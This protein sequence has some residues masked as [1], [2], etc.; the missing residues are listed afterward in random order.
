MVVKFVFSGQSFWVRIFFLPA[1]LHVTPCCYDCLL[2]QLVVLRTW[3]VHREHDHGAL[4]TCH[5]LLPVKAL[6]TIR[7]VNHAHHCYWMHISPQQ[8]TQLQVGT[9][10]VAV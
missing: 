9:A 8:D 7:Q 10:P 4:P 2:L 5:L 3:H 1:I 6:M